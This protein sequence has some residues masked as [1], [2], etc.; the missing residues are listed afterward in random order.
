MKNKS[1]P[2]TFKL[3]A[4]HLMIVMLGF[5][6]VAD[7]S[8]SK[9][10][11]VVKD[12]SRNPS[13]NG[14]DEKFLL[15]SSPYDTC[16]NACPAA[17][18]TEGGYH[19]ATPAEKAKVI[20]TIN[21]NQ[22]AN[23]LG[24]V[25]DSA[26]LCLP[27][28]VDNSRPTNV[29]EIK[30]DFCSC[31]AGK[32]DIINNCDSICAQKTPTD[33]PIL[34][35]TT[36]PGIEVVNNSKFK[37]LH[38]WC[39][40]QLNND[41]NRG[42]CQ[43]VATDGV[44]TVT[45]APEIA[46]GSNSFSVDI[47]QLAKNKTWILKLEEFKTG[48]F[49]QTKEFQ[50]NRKNIIDEEGAVGALAVTPINQYT[51]INYGIGV[52]NGAYV[53]DSFTRI[54]YFYPSDET[55]TPM[56]PHPTNS[57]TPATI[58]CHDENLFPGNDN[59]TYPRLEHIPGAFSMWDKNDPRFVAKAENG[60]RPTIN[61]IIDDRLANEY[62]VLGSTMNL[63]IP[64]NGANRPNASR[65]VMGFI[66]IPFKDSNGKTYCPTS[67][68]YNGA[69]PLM[70]ILG[71][72]MDDTEGL[73]L[74]EK[75]AELIP[76]TTGSNGDVTYKTVYG[77]M[78]AR[79]HTIRNYGFYVENGLKIRVNATTLHTKTVHFYWPVTTTGDALIQGTRRLFTVRTGATLAGE[80]T[81]TPPT[82]E[83]TTDKRVGCVPKTNSNL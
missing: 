28:I 71:D 81:T 14:C 70:N 30:P 60:S 59:I 15:Y 43:V 80:T 52:Q 46:V 50:I 24:I 11:G 82:S 23:L 36:I 62:S 16:V 13:S 6:C 17:T 63:F 32:S 26:N 19:L 25:N 64:I 73:Y 58:V 22:D 18:E 77:T 41:A 10:R 57:S 76:L 20:A 53:R 48:S 83:V 67:T 9:K 34:Y 37:T 79:E 51:C 8:V 7:Q 27:D 4:V 31:L 5:S 68:D 40:A 2:V 1:L 38:G 49:A 66:M 65:S 39:T 75:E 55:P 61:K 69:Q 56:P 35:V 3:L 54:F 72:Y 12:F 21:F 47:F 33:R 45:L 29:I 74:A 78:L 44:N 42:Q